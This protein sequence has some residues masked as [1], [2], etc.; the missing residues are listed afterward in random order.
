MST[1]QDHTPPT[2]AFVKVTNGPPE[3]VL[4]NIQ[5]N[6][7]GVA[8]ITVVSADN[9]TTQIRAFTPGSVGAIAVRLRK[10]DPSQGSVVKLEAADVAGNIH[11]CS[12]IFFAVHGHETQT[13]TGIDRVDNTI[14]IA[15]HGLPGLTYAVNGVSRHVLLSAGERKLIHARALFNRASN[16][17]SVTSSCSGVAD[18]VVWDGQATSNQGA[19]SDAVRPTWCTP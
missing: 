17:F 2:C 8:A 18:V 19:S 14:A 7:S 9:A 3:T 10:V 15:N 6:E 5:D 4:V 13:V 12:F 1:G 16:A 11:D